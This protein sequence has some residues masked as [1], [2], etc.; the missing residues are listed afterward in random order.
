MVGEGLC[1]TRRAL[2]R[3]AVPQIQPLS[4]SQPAPSTLSFFKGDLLLLIL[5]SIVGQLDEFNLSQ[6][7]SPRE[8][9]F[10]LLPVG[11]RSKAF[12]WIVQQLS[13]GAVRLLSSP[14][15]TKDPVS[16]WEYSLQCLPGM[17]S[18]PAGV[19]HPLVLT[20]SSVLCASM[21]ILSL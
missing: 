19:P 16:S 15:L 17:P 14:C 20:G 9:K 7:F 1:A 8:M 11:R 4:P 10:L 5:C 12:P 21:R 3:R 2:R 6:R 13:Q 18:S